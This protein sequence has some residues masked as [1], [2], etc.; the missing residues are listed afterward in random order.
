M[1]IKTLILGALG[2]NCY[3]LED[4]AT[5]KCAIIDPAD[6]VGRI[7]QETEK[8]GIDIE[9]IILTHTHFDH[10]LALN[11]LYEKTGAVVYVGRGD[12]AGL[13]EPTLNLSAFMGN[14]VCVF[15][16]EAR[17]LSEGDT[18]TFGEITLDVIET[19]GH[20][21][22]GICL[23]SQKDLCIFTGDTVF[24]GSIGRTDFPGGDY[25]TIINSLERVLSYPD[26]FLIYPGHGAATTVA[27]ESVCNPYRRY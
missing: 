3:I 27:N 1:R 24:A 18:V 14:A 9:C 4:T 12:K 26:E 16:G 2:T 8:R 21:P 22:G 10:M 7:L 23:I 20:T 25:N 5:R 17:V 13:F 19:A 11:E 15:S 6:D